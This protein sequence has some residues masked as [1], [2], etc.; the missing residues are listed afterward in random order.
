[1]LCV[2]EKSQ[3]QALDRT[4]PLLP[5]RPGQ[6]ERR[7]HDYVRHGTTSLF[8]AL[9]IKSGQGHRPAAIAAI[10]RSSSASSS[11]RSTPRC[12]AEL[13][14]HLIL[15]NYG[16]HKT[17]ADPALAREAA[18]LPSA[19][20]ADR[21]VLAQ[22]RRAL[23]RL[24]HREADPARRP[25]QHAR[26]RG[27][28]RR[29]TWPC[30]TRSRSPSSGPRPPMRSSRASPAFVIESRTQD[31]SPLSTSDFP[32]AA[33]RAAAPQNHRSFHR[34]R[35][36]G[37]TLG[38]PG[39]HRGPARWVTAST[40][41][42]VT[43]ATSSRMPAANAGGFKLFVRIIAQGRRWVSPRPGPARLTFNDRLILGPD[44]CAVRA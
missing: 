38:S 32:R 20:H 25:P 21:R 29:A 26:A 40:Q 33:R 41:R 14:V 6:V 16:T 4:Q 7:T 1:M 23:V 5:M 10:A 30:T 9:D 2:D 27:R 3:I 17:A 24:A 15:D 36:L 44:V 35:P 37:W 13:D 39:P 12:P 18:A 42:L 19:L 22:S 8:A 31:T 28:H 11:T 43:Q 34:R